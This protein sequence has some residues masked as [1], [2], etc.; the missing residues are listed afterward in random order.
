[1][2]ST[3]LWHQSASVTFC[4]ATVPKLPDYVTDWL[5]AWPWPPLKHRRWGQSSAVPFGYWNG[6]MSE[7]FVNDHEFSYPA[8]NFYF[9]FWSRLKLPLSKRML[10]DEFSANFHQLTIPRGKHHP[11]Q[12]LE[13]FQDVKDV[14]RERGLQS[15]GDHAI[16]WHNFNFVPNSLPPSTTKVVLGSKIFKSVTCLK[17]KSFDNY[18]DS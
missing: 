16:W 6:I 10:K 17:K 4:S 9:A 15:K 8:L 14:K 5:A 18:H 13:S 12:P 1:M 3:F 11:T 2:R 7:Y